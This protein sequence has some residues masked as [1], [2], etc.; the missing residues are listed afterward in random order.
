MSQMGANGQR[1]VGMSGDG[2]MGRKELPELITK[3]SR[4]KHHKYPSGNYSNRLLVNLALPSQGRNSIY[5]GFVG[6]NIE[7]QEKEI[8]K[9]FGLNIEKY[10][11]KAITQLDVN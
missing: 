9:E 10:D 8:N 6:T 7:S 5:S 4:Q 3:E 1:L 2:A 11:K